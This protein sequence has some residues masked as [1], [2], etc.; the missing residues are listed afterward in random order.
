MAGEGYGLESLN[1]GAVAQDGSDAQ[2]LVGL[3]GEL[4]VIEVHGDVEVLPVLDRLHVLH[5]QLAFAISDS[6]KCQDWAEQHCQKY[7]CLH[8]CVFFGFLGV[9]VLV[10]A[11]GQKTYSRFTASFVGPT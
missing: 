1:V 3:D 6:G 11:Y 4:G 10:R 8:D 7:L 5:L 9:S 2:F